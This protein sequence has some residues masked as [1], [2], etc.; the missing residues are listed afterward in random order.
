MKYDVL[1]D[2]TYTQY[3]TDN[4]DEENEISCWLEIDQT[5][6]KKALVKWK[7]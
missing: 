4:L 3:L 5:L 7:G 1:M 6:A 2:E